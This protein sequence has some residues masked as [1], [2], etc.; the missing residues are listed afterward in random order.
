MCAEQGALTF[1]EQWMKL[2]GSHFQVD[3]CD[4]LMT[5]AGHTLGIFMYFYLI[6]KSFLKHVMIFENH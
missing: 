5:E 3:T 6:D 4:E 2:G 1:R